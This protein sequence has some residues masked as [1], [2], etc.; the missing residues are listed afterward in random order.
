[1]SDR[2]DVQR[3][4]E[5]AGEEMAELAREGLESAREAQKLEI[6]RLIK[7]SPG[8]YFD[9]VTKAI[10]RKTGSQYQ[11][12]RHDRRRRDR[13]SQAQAEAAQF[14]LVTG[15]LFWDAVSKRLYRKASGH[16][17]LYSPDRRKQGGK[18]PT[19]KERRS[20]SV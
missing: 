6:A 14:R 8:Y 3:S 18:S 5:N 13:K 11:F 9:P 12:L 10:L 16:Y 20:K 19:G 7:L 4:L 15:G 17:V 1:M 2:F